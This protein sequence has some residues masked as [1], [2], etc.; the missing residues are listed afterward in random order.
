M[1]SAKQICYLEKK[2][3]AK[4]ESWGNAPKIV[5]KTNNV[6]LQSRI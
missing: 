6:Q 2:L 3:K 5:N 1:V 4:Q